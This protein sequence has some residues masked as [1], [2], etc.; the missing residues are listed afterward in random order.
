[1]SLP[2]A[3]SPVSTSTPSPASTTSAPAA[4]KPSHAAPNTSA[5]PGS[6]ATG[7][8][9]SAGATTSDPASAAKPADTDGTVALRLVREQRLRS[10]AEKARDEA[11]GKLKAAEP[12]AATTASFRAKWAA[13]DYVG[14]MREAFGTA[15]FSDDLLVALASGSEEPKPLTPEQMR[16]QIRAQLEEERTAAAT[17]ET[18]QM[19]TLRM[20]AVREVG[21]VLTAS[22][23]KW[24]T[25]WAV[26]VTGEQIAAAL[27]ASYDRATGR[28][29]EPTTLFD[30]LEQALRA[31]LQGLP[32]VPKAPEPPAAPRS[33]LSSRGPTDA[34]PEV[35]PQTQEER[36]AA[37]A[38]RDRLFREKHFGGG[39]K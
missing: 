38:E 35:K 18:T 9:P 29:A 33:F 37:R 4:E 30:G 27:D 1:M 5:T 3:L 34:A 26:G 10:G 12:H 19:Q 2:I 32:W 36:E 25:L 39:A 16:E 24:P 13:K 20:E 14:A 15:D 7:S 8:T 31:K 28:M 6:L 17:A 11:L 22:P 23:E 21:S